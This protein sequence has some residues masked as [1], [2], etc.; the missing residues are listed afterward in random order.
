MTTLISKLNEDG[1][2]EF[3]K[4][5]RQKL[6]LRAGDT[7]EFDFSGEAVTV[8]RQQ[9]FAMRVEKARTIVRKKL[10]AG[11]RCLSDELIAERRAEAA[12]EAAE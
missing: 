9:P 11:R 8:R 6:G 7:V 12:R 10:Q 4:E 5:V 3:P 1:Q 2:V